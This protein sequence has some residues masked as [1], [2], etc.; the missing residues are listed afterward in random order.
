MIDL[1][2]SKSTEELQDNIEFTE[3]DE[4]KI[5][6][7]LMG[8]GGEAVVGS[9]IRVIPD[10]R[11]ELSERRKSVRA[12]RNEG[13]KKALDK[14]GAYVEKTKTDLR[15]AK[16]GYSRAT[17][18]EIVKEEAQRLEA[19]IVKEREETGR[20]NKTPKP[21]RKRSKIF[22]NMG[23]TLEQKHN[24]HKYSREVKKARGDAKAFAEL[25]IRQREQSANKNLKD[26]ELAHQE[27]RA[28]KAQTQSALLRSKF[29]LD[30]NRTNFISTYRDA[31]QTQEERL[32]GIRSR[33]T[34]DIGYMNKGGLQKERIASANKE[35]SEDARQR[36]NDYF[37]ELK[38]P[39]EEHELVMAA[40]SLQP[41]AP[42]R[43]VA[44][45]AEPVVE[46]TV[47]AA[48]TGEPVEIIDHRQE[49]FD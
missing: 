48:P 28:R 30:G 12:K 9:G 47:W 49:N 13:L 10:S 46:P 16:K 18:K 15:F 40:E 19:Q 42:K 3:E 25:A 1:F 39:A 6:E 17:R 34:F 14:R 44:P 33:N 35:M 27:A 45:N 32:A 7:M 20:I 24:N 23:I 38:E 36:R 41:R 43:R 11:K 37:A 5:R 2:P 21:L 22:G 31:N 29:H 8:I 4:R 26:Y